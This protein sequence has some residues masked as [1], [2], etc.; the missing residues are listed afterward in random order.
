NFSWTRE[1]Q[2]LHVRNDVEGVEEEHLGISFHEF[3][4]S[5]FT[6]LFNPNEIIAEGLLNGELIFENLFEAPGIIADLN[7]DSLRVTEVPLGNLSLLAKSTEEKGYDFN[8]ALKDGDIDLDLVGDYLAAPSGASL[9]LNLD[10]NELKLVA[11]ERFTN[12]QIRDTE[13]DISGN[14]QLS[15]TTA[16]PVYEGSLQFNN[17]IFTV[18]TINSRFTLSNEAINL[19]NSGIYL[20]AFRI[21]DE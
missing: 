2:E 17:A 8:L 19:D 13:G 7:V 4:L 15:G 20:D 18:S 10:L 1:G 16:D 3:S 9:N 5:S 12:E 6:S 21:T 11:L 14:I